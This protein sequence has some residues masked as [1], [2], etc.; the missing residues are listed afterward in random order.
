MNTAAAGLQDADARLA[1]IDTRLYLVTDS[2][3]CR[4]AGRSVAETVREA[5][6]GGVGIVQ[7]RDKDIDDDAFCT[8]TRE[9]IAAVDT[10]TAGTK[11]RVPIVLNDRVAVAQR[12]LI[13]DVDVHIH[14]GQSDTPVQQVRE[15]IGPEPLIGLSAAN[16]AEF[17][18]AQ[19]SGAVDLLGIGPVYDTTTKNDAPVGIG[20]D[21]LGELVRE[22]G[23][24]AVA[25][26]G[27]NNDRAAE[28]RGRGLIGICVVSAICRAENPRAAAENLLAEFGD[29]NREVGA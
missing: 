27:I 21:R 23:L 12:L 18:A 14:V 24:P 5:V 1:G 7:V 3:Q 2:T 26:G 19:D 10:A 16:D 17:A 13:E 8:L 22:A 9:V 25:I 11:R 4:E 15:L 28:L 6:A 20:P 29:G